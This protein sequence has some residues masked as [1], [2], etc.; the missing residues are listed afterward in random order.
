M[1]LFMLQST[2]R[3]NIIKEKNEDKLKINQSTRY[4]KKSLKQSENPQTAK[5]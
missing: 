1:L 4:L 3:T 5:T 2:A